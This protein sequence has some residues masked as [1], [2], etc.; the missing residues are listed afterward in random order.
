MSDLTTLSEQ[1]GFPEDYLTFLKDIQD[2]ATLDYSDED[3][4]EAEEMDAELRTLEI[5]ED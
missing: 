4:L 5:D 3:A 1:S 2:G